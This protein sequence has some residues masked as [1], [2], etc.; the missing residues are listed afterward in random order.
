MLRHRMNTIKGGGIMKK[1]NEKKTDQV[2]RL[3]MMLEGFGIKTAKDLDAALSD[4]LGDL[5]IG[6]MTDRTLEAKNS[7]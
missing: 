5:T 3:K 1:A 4:T 6:I 7:A 2:D